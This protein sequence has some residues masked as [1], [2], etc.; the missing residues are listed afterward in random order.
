M[1]SKK[2][3]LSTDNEEV[4]NCLKRTKTQ[5]RSVESETQKSLSV[6]VS[7]FL[8]LIQTRKHRHTLK[9]FC[10]KLLLVETECKKTKK[11]NCK[12]KMSVGLVS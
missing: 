1:D 10:E 7:L 3:H 8:S 11:K 4:R 12:E 9:D 2:R 5:S 6:Y